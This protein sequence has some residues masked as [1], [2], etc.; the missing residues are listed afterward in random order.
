[1]ARIAV[2]GGAGFI[3]S[4]L[5]HKLL[6]SD[7]ESLH[8][9]DNMTMGNGLFAAR[10]DARLALCEADAADFA[11]TAQFLNT[12]QFD[13]IYH[14]AANSDIS[15]SALDS[16]VDLHHTF[17]TTAALAL[18]LARNPRPNATLVFASTSAVY[19]AH[20]AVIEPHTVKSPTSA[21]GWMKLASEKLLVTLLES[22][23]IGKLV[24]VRFPNVT[25]IG[26]THGVVKDLVAKYLSSEPWK[27]LGDG[28]QDKPYLHV[29]DLAEI[30]ASLDSV[31]PA[32]GYH[33]VNVA[34][35]S[36]TRVA[37]IVEMIEA[38][39]GKNRNPVYGTSPQGWPGD[40]P[41]YAYDTSELRSLGIQLPSSDDAILKSID[42]EFQ[43][44]GH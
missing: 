8:V 24:V 5:I 9:I 3:G 22:R 44:H 20:E 23:S 12:D 1:M 30:L 25:G 38:R 11:L 28:S 35:D 40:V 16:A 17:G 14:L 4:A 10:S 21:Y 7:I 31:F 36:S 39:G 6:D 34:P 41:T 29:E 13:V 42:E 15:K 19:G 43:R 37:K 26:Q 32:P 33:E 2:F 27:I 18:E